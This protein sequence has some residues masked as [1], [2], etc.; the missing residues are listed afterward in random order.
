MNEL[1]FSGRQVLVI[2]GSSG[3][4]NGIAQAFRAKGASVAVCGTRAK[5]S[6]YSA[7]EGSCLDGLDYFQLNVSDAGAIEKFDPP[8]AKLDV[9][10][11]RRA[12]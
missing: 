7:G 6:D 1:D 10:C 3:I 11:W 5:P 12:R 2:G 4:G 8:L 9:W